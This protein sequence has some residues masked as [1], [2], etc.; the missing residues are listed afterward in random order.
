VAAALALAAALLVQPWRARLD[1]DRDLS[2]PPTLA[3]LLSPAN[4]AAPF[5]V[6]FAS[7]AMLWVAA[8]GFCFASVQGCL[9]TFFVTQLTTEIGYALAVAGLAFSAMQVSGSF[10]RVL[11]GWIADRV[12]NARALVGLAVAS[13][14]MVTVVAAIAPGWPFWAVTLLG[15]VVG[16][17]STSWNGVYLAE[18]ARLAPAGRIGDATAGSTILT[19]GGYLVAPILFAIAVPVVGSYGACFAALA[20]VALLAVPMLAAAMRSVS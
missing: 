9:I 5:S 8:A 11:M 4:L 17:T 19:F 20:V 12:G 13:C 6:V 7:P 3:N 15:L 1:A 16:T 10:A 18:I 2:R 14:G